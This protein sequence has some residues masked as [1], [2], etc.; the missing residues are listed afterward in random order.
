L[1]FYFLIFTTT[2]LLLLSDLVSQNIGKTQVN[3]ED[4]HQEIITADKESKKANKKL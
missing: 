3:V 4:A 1:V 2:I